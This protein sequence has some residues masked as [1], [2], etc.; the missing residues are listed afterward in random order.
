MPQVDC[1][2]TGFSTVVIS[3]VDIPVIS[4]VDILLILH[5]FYTRHKHSVLT[6][7][8]SEVV[9][10]SESSSWRVT[11]ENPTFRGHLDFQIKFAHDSQRSPSIN[12][13]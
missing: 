9:A 5:S 12:C 10:I 13:L 8:S 1:E 11:K 7:L 2:V 3:Q 4:R 6:D